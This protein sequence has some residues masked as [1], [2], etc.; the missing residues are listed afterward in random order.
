LGKLKEAKKNFEEA[1][2]FEHFEDVTKEIEKLKM[3]SELY[4]KYEDF[5]KSFEES[6]ENVN[7]EISLESLEKILKLCPSTFYQLKECEILL[8]LEKFE[9]CLEI[10]SNILGIH[11]KNPEALHLEA[12]CFYYQG[13]VKKCLEKL[14]DELYIPQNKALKEKIDFIEKYSFEGKNHYKNKKFNESCESYSKAIELIDPNA[15]IL[16]SMLFCSRSTSLLNIQKF[17]EAVD[18]KQSSFS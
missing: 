4:K 6:H 15:K 7:L 9:K 13:N 11:P 3:I 10:C 2:T 12:K 16:N 5:D 17:K 14:N 18:G 1:S 8:K